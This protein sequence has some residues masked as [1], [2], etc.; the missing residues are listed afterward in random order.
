MDLNS[1][2]KPEVI[3]QEHLD[4]LA[5]KYIPVIECRQDRMPELLGKGTDGLEEI[6]NLEANQKIIAIEGVHHTHLER[7]IDL[8][9]NTRYFFDFLWKLSIY[10]IIVKFKLKPKGDVANFSR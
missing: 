6:S 10:L 7:I 4:A 2:K 5:A 3:S 8:Y 9:M 1:H